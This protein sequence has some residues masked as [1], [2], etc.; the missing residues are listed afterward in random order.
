[1]VYAMI[2]EAS[3]IF[4]GLVDALSLFQQSKEELP[5]AKQMMKAQSL[6]VQEVNKLDL[7]ALQNPDQ[8]AKTLSYKIYAQ[9][10]N[11][12]GLSYSS[13]STLRKQIDL[14]AVQAVEN[15][16]TSLATNPLRTLKSIAY[17]RLIAT[18]NAYDTGDIDYGTGMQVLL[19]SMKESN[20][21]LG[22][23]EKAELQDYILSEYAAHSYYDTAD[24]ATRRQILEATIPG[25][26]IAGSERLIRSLT[27]IQTNSISAENLAEL[28]KAMYDIVA[29][30]KP[31][32]RDMKNYTVQR[33]WEEF[34]EI[35]TLSPVAL[36]KES[37]KLD[38]A[39]TDKFKTETADEAIATL[40]S[41][42]NYE[43]YAVGV[44]LS[45]RRALLDQRYS[46][47]QNSLKEDSAETMY[48]QGLIPSIRVDF[49]DSA[50]NKNL[51]AYMNAYYDKSIKENGI[52]TTVLPKIYLD[53]FVGYLNSNITPE[54]FTT[55]L[56]QARAG[57]TQKAQ[58]ALLDQLVQKDPNLGVAFFMGKLFPSADV[59]QIMKLKGLTRTGQALDDVTAAANTYKIALYNNPDLANAY[60]KA[61]TIANDYNITGITK[62][63]ED[64][65][66]KLLHYVGPKIGSQTIYS[67]I[68]KW[69]PDDLAAANINQPIGSKLFLIN[70]RGRN[71]LA[72]DMEDLTPENSGHGTFYVFSGGGGYVV[73]QSGNPIEL[74]VESISSNMYKEYRRK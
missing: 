24:P 26:T 30:N 63:M 22:G 40:M 37:E 15:V 11:D 68:T 72:S 16:S 59:S 74:S 46:Y 55:A 70:T 32:A 5:L 8:T 45:I 52:A 67:I 10:G 25:M 31:A 54:Q 41:S 57:L 66:D 60:A 13:L 71:V 50:Q 47:L 29:G 6:L 43:S 34:Q 17:K 49:S 35:Q 7:D 3:E 48:K 69:S 23:Q 36:Q 12:S 19:N 62:I 73:D 18:Q 1:M 61:Y 21:Y 20:K 27:E 28:D 14:A 53:Q 2:D 51:F 33:A 38:K 65:Y 44:D 9:L 42:D 58:G 56:A 39:I 4:N 64:S